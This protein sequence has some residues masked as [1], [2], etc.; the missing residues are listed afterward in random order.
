MRDDVQGNELQNYCQKLLNFSVNSAGYLTFN[1]SA[2]SSNENQAHSVC[3]SLNLIVSV[4]QPY[5]YKLIVLILH[6]LLE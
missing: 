3:S 1:N 6:F 2:T 5:N 4:N